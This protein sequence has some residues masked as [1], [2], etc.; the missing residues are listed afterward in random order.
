MPCR[1]LLLPAIAVVFSA[2]NNSNATNNTESIGAAGVAIVGTVPAGMTAIDGG[3]FQMGTNEAQ[4]YAPEQPAH[5]VQVKGFY[6]DATEVTNKQFKEFVEATGYKT[7]AERKPEWEELKQQLPPGT[8][9][10]PDDE[11]IP[12][13]MV[14]IP[15][16]HPVKTDN[17]GGW[18]KWVPGADWQHP[19]GPGSNLNGRWN[20]PVVQVAWEDANAYAKWAGKRLPTEAE[21]EYAARGGVAEKRYAWGDDF[22]P[23]HHFMA[24]TFQGHFPDKDT[25][26]DGF[27]GT[28]PVGSFPANGYGLYDMIG[29]VWEWTA[30]WYD[31]NEYKK[32][33]TKKVTA[34]PTGPTKTYDPD[35]PYAMQRVT[36]GGSFL[37]SND[38]CVN[39]RPSARR[40]T[41]HDS[42]AS[43]IGFRC[44]KDK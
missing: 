43:H 26:E 33:D 24:N 36:K 17:I 15:P 44:V 40:G 31:A 39:Y 6:M 22:T 25:K 10:P 3:S 8:P 19:E 1:F 11:L 41:A 16:S 21:W 5:P 32:M 13:S 18:W 34:N 9:A 35:D 37:C 30:D 27:A 2:C 20:H 38:Y 23:Q 14:F 4:S 7:I 28:A 12:G 42:G 29:N